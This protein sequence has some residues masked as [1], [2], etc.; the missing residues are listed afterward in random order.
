MLVSAMLE[1][2]GGAESVVGF[3][4]GLADVGLDEDAPLD[5]GARDNDDED[6][7]LDDGARHRR[8][9]AMACLESVATRR[10]WWHS[11]RKMFVERAKRPS[12]IQSF[13]DSVD[14]AGDS[15]DESCWGVAPNLRRCPGDILL[16]FDPRQKSQVEVISKRNNKF[17]GHEGK[18]KILSPRRQE[19]ESTTKAADMRMHS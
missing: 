7:L 14:A 1:T 8:P 19:Q 16:R 5:D 11:R 15:A 3:D 2:P 13:G 10:C 12:L 18:S 9:S 17:C 6:A 4:V